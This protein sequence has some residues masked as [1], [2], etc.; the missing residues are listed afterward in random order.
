[1][2]STKKK[3]LQ[4]RI[5]HAKKAITSILH[6][7]KYTTL[8]KKQA[9]YILKKAITSILH[10]KKNNYK[11]STH[12]TTKITSILHTKKYIALKKSSY[13]HFTH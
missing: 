13:K 2:Y 9:F 1:M 3:Q 5:L 8:K 10:F 11:Y 4:A 7:K 12:Y 6:T